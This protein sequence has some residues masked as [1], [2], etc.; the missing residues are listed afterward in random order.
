MLYW[1][2]EEDDVLWYIGPQVMADG[3]YGEENY[4]NGARG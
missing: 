1:G 2:S 4:L 3:V